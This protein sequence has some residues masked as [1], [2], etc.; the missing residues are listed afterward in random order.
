MANGESFRSMRNNVRK[1]LQTQMDSSLPRSQRRALA[2]E[3]EKELRATV[4][5]ARR[6]YTTCFESGVG[7]MADKQL[8]EFLVEYNNRISKGVTLPANFEALRDFFFFHR[9]YR[10]FVLKPE[11]DHLFAISDF[12]DFA[13]SPDCA[14]DPMKYIDMFEDGVIYS[15]NNYEP[16]GD[17]T[18]STDKEKEFGIGAISITRQ[19]SL[20]D[21]FVTAG[22]LDT[23]EDLLESI[24]KRPVD[25]NMPPGKKGIAADPRRKH[26]PLPLAD[27]G[28]KFLHKTMAMVRF[29]AYS[30]K[31][32]CQYILI[33]WGDRY[34]V[35]SDDPSSA[36]QHSEDERQKILHTWTKQLISYSG[37]WGLCPVF[38]ALPHYFDFKLELVRDENP[39]KEQQM[40]LR[41]SSEISKIPTL[42]RDIKESL[43]RVRRIA[44]LKITAGN[45]SGIVRRFAP[46]TYQVDVSGFWRNLSPGSF[47]VD[48]RGQKIEGR[49]WVKGHTRWRSLPVKPKEVLI[50]SRIAIARAIAQSEELC[51]Q[52]PKQ[53]AELRNTAGPQVETAV[54]SEEVSRGEAYLERRKLTKKLRFRIL[55]RDDYRCVICG[56]DAAS[57]RS[58]RLDV[59]HIVP[60]SRGGKTTQDNLRTLCSQCNNGKG[61][62]LVQ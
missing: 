57:D 39:Q 37:L 13:T 20:I 44:A 27:D 58:V 48:S 49:T 26:E 60:I 15:Y 54:V 46:P 34:T 41:Y 59:D 12:I 56:V 3:K 45:G 11:R 8:R 42:P 16:P 43:I 32:V 25:E 9:E 50:K 10:T 62:E 38:L 53:E 24:D 30:K 36:M 40:A 22:Q 23:R 31:T 28:S 51:Q 21:V 33:D 6:L 35:I 19:G 1:A 7:L 47:G 17:M 5:V 4:R 61:A 52:V 14:T 29:D 55:D 18:I 2:K